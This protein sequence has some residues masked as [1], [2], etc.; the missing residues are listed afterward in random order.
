[1]ST[2]SGSAQAELVEP[3]VDADI[4]TA[5]DIPHP[6]ARFFDRASRALEERGQSE[7]RSALLSA[8]SGRVVEVGAGNGLNFP[9]YP[10]SVS[11]VVAVEPEPYLRAGAIEAAASAPVPVPR[12]R[13]H[14]R[15][16]AARGRLGRCGGGLACSLLRPGSGVC[17]GRAAPGHPGRR[18][19]ALL[20][21]RR[22]DPTSCRLCA[23][24]ARP[25]L[26]APRRRLPRKSRHTESD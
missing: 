1:M 12:L 14:R 11:E 5:T 4:S 20:R 3:A 17:A 8:L 10:A 24:R 21:A 22:L 16:A 23:A 15:G 2:R 7:H 26:A 18:R 13:R 6:L 19:A 25:R 9:H